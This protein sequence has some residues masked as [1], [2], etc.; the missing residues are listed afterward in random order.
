[1]AGPM[2]GRGS[3]LQSRAIKGAVKVPEH[4]PKVKRKVVF[5]CWLIAKTKLPD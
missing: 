1:M 3:S 4:P 5:R 2:A